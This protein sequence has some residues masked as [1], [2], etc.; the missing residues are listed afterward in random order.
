[1]TKPN[2]VLSVEIRGRKF[3]VWVYSS[4]EFSAE[5]NGQDVRALSLE[6]LKTKLERATAHD[7]IEPIHFLEWDGKRLVRCKC[8]GIHA[9]TG[10]LVIVRENEDGKKTTYQEYRVEGAIRPELEAEYRPLCEAVEKAEAARWAFEEGHS[11]DMKDAV[12]EATAK[13]SKKGGAA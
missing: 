8:T 13:K 7:R 4:G 11:F 9:S 12:A 3:D 6:Q 1:M 10:N 2:P 5:Y